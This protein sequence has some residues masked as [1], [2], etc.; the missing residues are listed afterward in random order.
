MSSIEYELRVVD[1]EPSSLIKK[2]RLHGGK[3]ISKH[4]Y[5]RYV[6]DVSPPKLG[7]WLRLRTDGTTTT[8]TAKEVKDD[9]VDGTHEWEI[10]VNDFSEAYEIL[11]KAGMKPKSYQENKRTNFELK[12][13]ILSIDQWPRIPICLELES[14]HEAKIRDVAKLLGFTNKQLT[15]ENIQK[16]YARFGIDL[17]KEKE[18][19]LTP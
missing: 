5:K 8:L 12:G 7:V 1:V 19:R 18:L 14:T 15:G 10:E 4:L 9:T 6:F 17:D 11:T 16:I 3:Q 2:I 13:V